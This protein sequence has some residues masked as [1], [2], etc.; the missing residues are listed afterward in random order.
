MIGLQFHV[1]NIKNTVCGRTMTFRD[2]IKA[3]ENDKGEILHTRI[4]Q[5]GYNFLVGLQVQRKLI[6]NV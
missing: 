1:K 4:H 5:I 6:I 2:W 3:S